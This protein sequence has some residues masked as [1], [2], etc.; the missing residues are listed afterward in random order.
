MTPRYD[1]SD[2]TRF[3]QMRDIMRP[4]DD[5]DYKDWEDGAPASVWEHVAL[6]TL[7]VVGTIA[8][9]WLAIRAL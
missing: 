7:C 9:G 8:L 6:W 5:H 4:S 2:P 1:F 3:Q